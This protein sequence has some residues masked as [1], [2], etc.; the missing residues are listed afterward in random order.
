MGSHVQAI[1]RCKGIDE[2]TL[3]KTLRALGV[4]NLAAALMLGGCGSD[5]GG[6]EDGAVTM[7]GG[8]DSATPVDGDVEDAS[9]SAVAVDA[10]AD[11]STPTV[12]DTDIVLVRLNADGTVDNTYGTD[13]VARVSL[14]SNA[15]T[16]YGIDIHRDAT[17]ADKVVIFGTRNT[18]T[19]NDSARVTARV[20]ADGSSLDTTFAT[21]G[22]HA[23]SIP[24]VADSARNGTVLA[25]GT[26][27]SSGYSPVPTNVGTMTSNRVVLIRLSAT[28]APIASFGANGIANVNPFAATQP[29]VEHGMAEAYGAA[30]L[31]NGTIVTTGYG[32][33]TSMVDAVAQV[34]FSFTAN[35]LLNEAGWPGFAPA[36]PYMPVAGAGVVHPYPSFEARGRNVVGLPGNAGLFVGSANGR[37][38]GTNKDIM[39]SVIDVA[40]NPTTIPVTGA[41]VAET[42][43]AAHV[44]AITGGEDFSDEA[45]F[46]AA[47]DP[48]GAFAVIAGYRQGTVGGVAQD[49]DGVLGI[50]TI[51]ETGGVT[52]GLTLTSLEAKAASTTENDHFRTATIYNPAQ[53]TTRIFV[54]GFIG[55]NPM[56]GT[57][58]RRMLV[59]CFEDTGAVCAD[60]GTNGF[61]EITTARD[62]V[63]LAVDSTGRVI[64]AG[65]VTRQVPVVTP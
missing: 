55:A 18:T 58:T 54:S 37:T 23:F 33:V 61:V 6:D 22:V 35:G 17:H 38:A 41:N 8:T 57:D 12:A 25:D 45:C 39:V 24:G 10:A 32:R 14:G 48:D 40:G 62:A 9:D 60:F 49:T 36:P 4:L 52:T 47:T 28:G 26:I 34:N 29:N 5:D 59:G 2:M 44:L 43:N 31:E 42:E 64:V 3:D 7:D 51:E 27:L 13:G 50:F 1:L 30:V 20:L 21:A 56:G 53:G 15:D 16:V 11:G 19:S 63:G 46:G 65:T